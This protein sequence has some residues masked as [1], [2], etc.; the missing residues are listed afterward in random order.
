MSSTNRTSVVDLPARRPIE[1]SITD[2]RRKKLSTL[3]ADTHGI[4]SLAFSPDG[5]R[6]AAAGTS[7]HVWE[8]PDGKQSP[9]FEGHGASV[10]LVAFSTDGKTLAS[11]GFDGTARFWETT[12]WRQR[13][14]AAHP[15]MW[16]NA[17]AFSPSLD[18][19]AHGDTSTR[20]VT[21]VEARTGKVP[22]FVGIGRQ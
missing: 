10:S 4:A 7:I 18:V 13:H 2:L 17:S 22:V 1:Y 21:L 11:L 12:T 6:L 19:L 16:S 8:L 5:K 20:R 3:K 15:R 9:E 14:Q